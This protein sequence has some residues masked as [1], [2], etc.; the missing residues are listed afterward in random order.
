MSDEDMGFAALGASTDDYTIDSEWRG[1]SPPAMTAEYYQ[2]PHNRIH[3]FPLSDQHSKLH[4]HGYRVLDSAASTGHGSPSIGKDRLL[5]DQS[6]LSLTQQPLTSSSESLFSSSQNSSSDISKQTSMTALSSLVGRAEETE[7]PDRS[8]EDS[9]LQTHENAS[10]LTTSRSLR[11]LADPWSLKQQQPHTTAG[12]DDSDM[13]DEV[14]QTGD[15]THQ[16]LNYDD[17]LINED[18]DD[19]N[20]VNI[21]SINTEGVKPEVMDPNPDLHASRF[22]GVH[23]RLH[24]DATP[25][26]PPLMTESTIG[27]D[28]SPYSAGPSPFD[29]TSA[30][31]S[32]TYDDPSTSAFNTPPP[33]P[34]GVSS[35]APIV[36]DARQHRKGHNKAASVS[37]IMLL[38]LL[39]TFNGSNSCSNTH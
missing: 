15:D 9:V 29:F 34:S 39:A 4:T 10:S 27:S 14:L 2:N 37:S 1:D 31:S 25:P 11:S 21:S 38:L 26:V 32:P 30:N 17:Y 36:D 33:F 16:N 22:D 6:A 13:V 5:E 3:H 23:G 18:E 28:L 35:I 12:E 7:H 19:I 24:Q 8:C 20:K